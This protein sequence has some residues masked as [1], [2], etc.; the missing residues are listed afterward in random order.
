MNQRITQVEVKSRINVQN[1]EIVIVQRE[2]LP[3]ILVVSQSII[4][5]F[6]DSKH[7]KHVGWE[8]IDTN[9]I[10]KLQSWF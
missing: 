4:E 1:V 9:I 3:H 6:I 10:A 2:I 8:R 5:I 7:H